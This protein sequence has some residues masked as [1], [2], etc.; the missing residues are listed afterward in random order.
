MTYELAVEIENRAWEVARK[1]G[2]DIDD[3]FIEK[4][5]AMKALYDS[6]QWPN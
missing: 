5:A 1:L 6:G 3:L 2:I 4:L